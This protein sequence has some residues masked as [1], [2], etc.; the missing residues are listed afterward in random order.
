[1]PSDGIATL[2]A[3]SF[4]ND[5]TCVSNRGLAGSMRLTKIGMDVVPSTA[6]VPAWAISD[7]GR[8]YGGLQN[9]DHGFKSHRRL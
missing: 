4:L 5:A 6:E 7:C 3:R 1:M 8:R 2:Q 9:P